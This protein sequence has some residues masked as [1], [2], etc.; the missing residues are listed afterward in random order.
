[1]EPGAAMAAPSSSPAQTSSWRL[2]IFTLLALCLVDGTYTVLRRYSRGVLME[3]YSFN[4]VLLVAEFLKLAVAVHM[5]R[6]S[7]MKERIEEPLSKRLVELIMKSR[8]MLVLALL[9][10][11]GNSLSYVAL[12]RIGA[13]TFVIIAQTKTLATALFSSLI[14]RRQY[15]WPKWRALILLVAGVVLFVLPTID[16][17]P[18]DQNSNDYETMLG[19]LLEIVVVMI[20]GFC[21]IYFEKVIKSDHEQIGI[22]ERNFQLACWSIPSYL[23]LIQLREPRPDG[24]FANWTPLAIVLSLFGCSGGLLVALTIKYGDSVLKT[25]AISGSIIY[26][27]LFDQAFLGGPLTFEM[28]VSASVVIIAICNYTFDLSPDSATKWPSSAGPSTST[29]TIQSGEA[30]MNTST[31]KKHENY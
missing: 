27:A 15:S 28:G 23:M 24:Y 2:R 7:M 3:T 21:S 14:L 10:G 31:T 17:G 11:A 13:G 12:R 8:K 4:E 26:A 29:A 30:G 20:S 1:M 5:I 9:Y 16:E 25:L 22:W 18:I 6:G 19:I